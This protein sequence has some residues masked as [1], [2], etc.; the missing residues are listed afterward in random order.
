V[1][2]NGTLTAPGAESA[3]LRNLKQINLSRIELKHL[4]REKANCGK[5][6]EAYFKMGLSVLSFAAGV[7]FVW[8]GRAGIGASY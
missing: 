6:L 8:K 5:T 2:R 3:Q 7:F 1:R 4:R